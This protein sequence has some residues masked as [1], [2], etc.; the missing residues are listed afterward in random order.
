VR[1]LRG[2]VLLSLVTIA[3]CWNGP[4]F[5]GVGGSAGTAGT[6]GAGGDAGAGGAGGGDA[7]SSDDEALFIILGEF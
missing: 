1:R 7:A 3:S 5:G 4:G 2:L 6:G